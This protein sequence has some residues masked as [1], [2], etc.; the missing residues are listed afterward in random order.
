MK[1]VQYSWYC[2][3]CCP[4]QQMYMLKPL[5]LNRQVYITY[6][7]FIDA[8]K[9]KRMI[10]LEFKPN[11]PMIRH[12]IRMTGLPS[13]PKTRLSPYSNH[14]T[15]LQLFSIVDPYMNCIPIITPHIIN[16]LYKNKYSLNGKNLTRMS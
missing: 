5:L 8:H 9:P 6:N 16:T 2:C 14:S 15:V 12:G 3:Y 1:S 11:A 13:S 7:K 4:N 10:Y